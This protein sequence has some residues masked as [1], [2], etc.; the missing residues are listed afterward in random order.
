MPG[1]HIGGSGGNRARVAREREEARLASEHA[2]ARRAKIE[3]LESRALELEFASPRAKELVVE[4]GVKPL[5]LAKSTP[6]H[7]NGYTADDVRAVA[8]G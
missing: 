4:L 2:D 8:N 6:S 7:E 1:S 5:D 3:K